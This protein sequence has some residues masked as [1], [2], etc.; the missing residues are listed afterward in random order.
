MK[1]TNLRHIL[2]TGILS[3]ICL[4]HTG[5]S[6][7]K[8]SDKAADSADFVESMDTATPL[9]TIQE[10]EP[11]EYTDLPDENAQI[12]YMRASG[13]WDKYSEGILPQMAHDQP[14]YCE[15]L[16]NNPHDRFIIVDKGRMKV[17]LYD[18]YGRMEKKY[19]M[20]CAKNFGTKHKKGDS[21]TPEGFFSVEGRYDST[22]GLFTD[23]DGVT[24]PKK[25]QFGPRFIRLLTPGTRSIGIHG[26]CAPWS[27]GGRSSHGCIRITNENIMELVELVEPGMPVIV[28]PG[29]RD[30]RANAREGYSIPTVSPEPGMSRIVVK[31][32]PPKDE[33]ES[34]EDASAGTGI[35]SADSVVGHGDGAGETVP[36]RES[37]ARPDTVSE[38]DPDTLP[39]VFQ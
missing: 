30:I 19:G 18:R 6:Q 12:A 38:S 10:P 29:S 20:A 36:D 28:S 27:I 22:D 21:R 9:D 2:L 16:L 34:G 7:R 11:E 15:R 5:C 13:F 3:L 32:L 39:G 35:V 25:G 14:D 1:P 8:A 23:D 4:S 17:Y 37:A 26:T 31:N 33:P 24:S